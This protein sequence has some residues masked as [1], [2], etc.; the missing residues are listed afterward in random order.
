MRFTGFTT[1]LLA[2]SGAGIVSG[3][4]LAPESAE[5]HLL[6]KRSCY[7]TGEVWGAQLDTAIARV[8]EAC[9]PNGGGMGGRDWRLG[10]VATRC[11]DIGGGKR[12][13]IRTERRV[14]AQG[15]PFLPVGD[16]VARLRREVRSCE[17]AGARP[18][19][20]WNIAYV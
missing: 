11:Y 10:E 13:D 3:I 2:L 17:R 6:A 16:C 5:P 18:F 20:D 8:E 15:G 19:E 14:D 9:S 12:I 7:T 4:K 1:L